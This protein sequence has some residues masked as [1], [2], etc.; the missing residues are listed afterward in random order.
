MLRGRFQGD[1][2][3]MGGA[4]TSNSKKWNVRHGAE[5]Q[6]AGRER[7]GELWGIVQ[8]RLRGHMVLWLKHST[9]LC[10]TPS[11]CPLGGASVTQRV[12]GGGGLD[13][14]RRQQK[15]FLLISKEAATRTPVQVR[16]ERL[17]DDFKAYGRAFDPAAG[18]N[19]LGCSSE[20]TAD[21][22]MTD[23][24]TRVASIAPR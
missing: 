1:V 10:L 3:L 11:T 14:H 9:L 2:F 7:E 15:M 23:A 21:W 4:D 6:Q 22:P 18:V 20:P 13:V 12:T 24:L 17:M 16:E 19:S 8:V 5:R